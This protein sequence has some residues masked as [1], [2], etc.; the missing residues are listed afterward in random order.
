MGQYSIFDTFRD[1][2]TERVGR[3]SCPI[4]HTCRH[5]SLHLFKQMLIIIESIEITCCTPWITFVTVCP[6]GSSFR[7]MNCQVKQWKWRETWRY[8]WASKC[9]MDSMQPEISTFY[10]PLYKAWDKNRFQEGAAEWFL[11]HFMNKSTCAAL[12]TSAFLSSS[13]QAAQKG[14]LTPCCQQVN[15]FSRC[16]QPTTSLPRPKCPLWTSSNTSVRVEWNI[17]GPS[18]RSPLSVGQSTRSTISNERSL[19]S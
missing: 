1:K 12:N 11:H 18:G 10:W 6:K 4:F 3:Q 5:E 19:K 14:E 13:I 2:L 15:Y 16:W 17:A 8:S 9:L 7:M